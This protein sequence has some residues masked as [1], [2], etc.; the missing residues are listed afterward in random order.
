MQVAGA[1][2]AAAGVAYAP[3][4]GEMV[5]AVVVQGGGATRG[6]LERRVRRLDGSR[7]P[8]SMDRRYDIF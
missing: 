6:R 2:V 3:A 4:A 7:A 5:V 8:R 1:P